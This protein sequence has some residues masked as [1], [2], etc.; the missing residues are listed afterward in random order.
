MA[1]TPEHNFGEKMKCAGSDNTALSKTKQFS[2]LER[3]FPNGYKVSPKN[4]PRPKSAILDKASIDLHLENFMMN[5][6][7]SLNDGNELRIDNANISLHLSEPPMM[8]YVTPQQKWNSPSNLLNAQRTNGNERKTIPHV[9]SSDNE[10]REQ[11]YKSCYPNVQANGDNRTMVNGNNTIKRNCDIYSV[12]TPVALTPPTVPQR[13]SQSIPRNMSSQDD[14][15]VVL[16]PRSLDRNTN[17]MPPSVPTRRASNILPLRTTTNGIEMRKS[18][19]MCQP[20]D[21]A[22]YSNMSEL[23]G[24]SVGSIDRR[25]NRPETSTACG[26]T[27]NQAMLEKQL[28][29][30][31]EQLRTITESVKRYS[32]QA[33]LLQE[34]KSQKKQLQQS[35]SVDKGL[36]SHTKPK[37]FLQPLSPLAVAD[38]ENEE[39]Q[40]PSHKLK[41]FLES[42]RSSMREPDVLNNEN[43]DD[44]YS[45]E[46]NGKDESII[47]SV[48][49]SESSNKTVGS[50]DDS[51]SE[52]KAPTEQLKH[53]LNNNQFYDKRILNSAVNQNMEKPVHQNTFLY[54]K[55]SK[56]NPFSNHP[57][58]SN[59]EPSD[60]I[61]SNNNCI[62]PSS[63][64]N[65]KLALNIAETMK[66]VDQILD[67]FHILAI[68]AKSSDS[69]EYLKKCS[70][71]LKQ[72]SEQFRLFNMAYGGISYDGN[73]TTTVQPD[74]STC[75]ISP[76]TTQEAVNTL[77]VQP[78][79][80]F[81]IMDHRISLFN[82]ILD[83]QDRFSQVIDCDVRN[84]YQSPFS[85]QPMRLRFY[86]YAYTESYK[87]LFTKHSLCFMFGGLIRLQSTFF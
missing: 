74:E 5:R 46:E 81:Q 76:G 32:E 37:Q 2:I 13:R 41:L 56:I 59:P 78:R 31:S 10:H 83:T 60:T 30:Y 6:K 85:K 70:D 9:T 44:Q 82:N 26:A 72:T 22:I 14:P 63:Q 35:K 54:P 67:K 87:D 48:G 55:S 45:D 27:P 80:G 64:N 52:I 18:A 38:L 69:V 50:I 25:L 28:R 3:N 79:N 34:L 20:F 16:R 21:Q 84:D 40:T 86:M 39:V 51:T 29:L 42:I 24:K 57:T 15:I 12:P 43:G 19:T 61:N 75:C 49:P 68:N 33:K 8:P 23:S 17:V 47:K 1:S 71:A 11:L 62:L 66:T 65:E 77:L 7:I 53:A 73:G 36:S 4:S 58:R